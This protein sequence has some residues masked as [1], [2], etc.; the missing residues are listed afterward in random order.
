MIQISNKN[1]PREKLVLYPPHTK[2]HWPFSEKKITIIQGQIM[3]VKQLYYSTE[4]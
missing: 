1:T 3:Y 2:V 4:F